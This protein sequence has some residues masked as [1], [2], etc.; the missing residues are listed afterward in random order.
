MSIWPRIWD[1]PATSIQFSNWF[2]WSY[3][4]AAFVILSGRVIV[5]YLAAASLCDLPSL[6]ELLK[7]PLSFPGPS[8][9]WTLTG[10]CC[11][12]CGMRS[13]LGYVLEPFCFLLLKKPPPPG[14]GFACCFGSPSVTGASTLACTPSAS[15]FSGSVGSVVENPLEDE[16]PLIAPTFPNALIYA[17]GLTSVEYWTSPCNLEWAYDNLSV[18]TKAEFCVLNLLFFRENDWIYD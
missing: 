18:F 13:T 9:F 11:F 1:F 7:N 16:S 14:L 17:R 2:L 8:L 12:P 4:L 5:I 15:G 3:N 6:S 10:Y